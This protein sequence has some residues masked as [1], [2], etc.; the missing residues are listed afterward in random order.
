M[1]AEAKTYKMILRKNE[2]TL[3]LVEDTC[4]AANPK[5]ATDIFTERHGR[6][7]VVSGPFRIDPSTG[8]RI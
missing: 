4:T 5:E 6:G 3:E 1:P 8:K 2:K 7:R